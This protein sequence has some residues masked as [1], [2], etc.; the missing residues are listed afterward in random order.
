[1][2][3]DHDPFAPLPPAAGG[4]MG[5]DRTVVRPRP[6]ARGMSASAEPRFG[7][8]DHPEPS[9]SMPQASG[10]LALPESIAGDNPLV[11][12]AY[13]LLVLVDQIRSTAHHPDP[14]GLRESL[15]EGLRRFESD[16]HAASLPR[17]TIIGAR[18][19]LCTFLDETVTSTPWGGSGAWASDPLL[20]RFHNEAWGGEKVFQLL[21]KLAET[22]AKNVDLLELIYACLALGFEGRYRVADNGRAQ[23]DTLRE[24]LFLMLRRERPAPE[25]ALSERW[26]PARVTRR[27]WIDATP[28]WVFCALLG[29]LTVGAFLLYNHWLAERSDPLFAS[30]QTLRLGKPPPPVVPVPA[31]RPRLAAF[32]APEIQQGLVA[33][34]DDATK[35]VITIRGDGS[36]QPGSAVVSER[37]LPLLDR[38]GSALRDTPGKVLISGHTDN[39]PIRSTR[40]PSNWHLS[41][42]RALAVQQLLA[43]SVAP[44]RMSADGRADAEPIEANDTPAGRARNRRVE[45][46]LFV[47]P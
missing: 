12:A 32:L 35:S 36:F 37:L 43:R 1:M 19:V 41:R 8:L 2:N 27:R 30:I 17:E 5:S 20:V 4:G 45:I 23:L 15:S 14:V 34:R 21:A 47:T 46:T 29:V 26:L 16:A 22:P 40:F 33:V 42:D 28:F 6:G 11:G 10:R 38:I 13:P 3:N 7:G 44:Q 31:A 9:L 39:V 25:P 18:Y 24:R